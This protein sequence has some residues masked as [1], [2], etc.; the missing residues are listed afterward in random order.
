MYKLDP[1]VFI[2]KPSQKRKV[3]SNMSVLYRYYSIFIGFLIHEMRIYLLLTWDENGR[4]QGP[5]LGPPIKKFELK[6]EV[7]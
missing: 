4:V 2:T 3:N 7:S 1:I 6:Y 5:A